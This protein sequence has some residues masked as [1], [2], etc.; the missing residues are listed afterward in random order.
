MCC[1]FCVCVYLCLCVFVCV[2]GAKFFGV[3]KCVGEFLG[4]LGEIFW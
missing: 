3:L 1:V 4:N 2:C